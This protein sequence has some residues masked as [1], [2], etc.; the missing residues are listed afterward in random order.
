MATVRCP[1]TDLAL[2]MPLESREESISSLELTNGLRAIA[3]H[4]MI[5]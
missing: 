2:Q 4:F 1:G 5:R 3:A